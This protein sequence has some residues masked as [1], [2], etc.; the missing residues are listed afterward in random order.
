M[1]QALADYLD[2][3]PRSERRALAGPWHPHP[4]HPHHPHGGGWSGPIV[5]GGGY[6]P[7]PAYSPTFVVEREPAAPAAAPS[8]V[9]V[10]VGARPRCGG[11]IAPGVWRCGPTTFYDV[12]RYELR[13]N[14]LVAKALRGLGAVQY[15]GQLTTTRKLAPPVKTMTI[16]PSTPSL[17]PLRAANMIVAPL[18]TASTVM[19]PGVP[20][21]FPSAPKASAPSAPE[22]QYFAPTS[23]SGGSSGSPNTA[24]SEQTPVGCP[25]GASYDVTVGT[26]VCD[27]G[28]APSV[29]GQTCVPAGAGSSSGGSASAVGWFALIVGAVVMARAVG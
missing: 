29:N 20:V 16:A 24:P 25:A 12:S 4:H 22:Q 9:G 7:E 2:A 28:F 26:C 10:A 18:P 14:G 21:A 15:A 27:P 17:A 13:A 3:L 11:E 23:P 19:R 5:W 8:Y 6:Y 1:E